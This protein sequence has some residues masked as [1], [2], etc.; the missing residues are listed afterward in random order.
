[1]DELIW[2]QLPCIS[3]REFDTKFASLI[4]EQMNPEYVR[5]TYKPDPVYICLFFTYWW[6][7]WIFTS[8]LASL[9]GK[10]S[11][12]EVIE[13]SEY[14]RHE[15]IGG[16]YA[17]SK[18]LIDGVFNLWFDVT[19]LSASHSGIVTGIEVYDLC[20]T[21]TTFRR[22]WRYWQYLGSYFHRRPHSRHIERLLVLWLILRDL[23][24]RRT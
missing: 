4:G 3:L 14:A 17:Y 19:K 1:M 16:Y 12:E 7:V 22:V 24:T 9:R 13:P 5:Q 23:F 8:Q 10:E 18:E 15:I 21:N 11:F 2:Q 6:L 20:E